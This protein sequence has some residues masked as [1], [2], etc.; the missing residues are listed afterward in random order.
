MSWKKYGG[1]NKMQNMN[2]IT[3]NSLVT[4]KFTVRDIASEFQIQALTVYGDANLKGNAFITGNIRGEGELFLSGS[5]FLGGRKLTLAPAETDPTFLQSNYLNNERKIGLNKLTAQA[6]LDILGESYRSLDVFSDKTN[7]RNILARTGQGLDSGFALM[8]DTT[9]SSIEIYNNG[10]VNTNSNLSNS[11]PADLELNYYPSGT[12]EITGKDYL[13]GNLETKIQTKLLIS[14][15][16][17]PT[18]VFNESLIVYDI[19]GTTFNNGIYNNGSTAGN[20]LSL[21]A[22]DN[23]ANTFLNITTPNKYGLQISGGAYSGDITR[24]MGIIDVSNVFYQTNTNPA[25]IVVSGKDKSKFT[26]TVGFNTYT[27]I[28]DKYSM[29]INGLINISNNDLRVVANPTFEVLNVSFYKNNPNYAIMVG[30]PNSLGSSQTYQVLYSHDGGI[31]WNI[32]SGTNIFDISDTTDINEDYDIVVESIYLQNEFNSIIAT[33]RRSQTGESSIVLKSTNGGISYSQF[34]S[35]VMSLSGAGEAIQYNLYY[36]CV[37]INPPDVND[38]STI[39]V[40]DVNGLS[41]FSFKFSNSDINIVRGKTT[42]NTSGY[43][44]KY[45]DGSNNS[46]YLLTNTS[47]IKFDIATNNII[48][49]K[50]SNSSGTYNKLR[51]YDENVVIAVGENVI[52]YT[53][54]GGTTWNV[55]TISGNFTDV[56]ILDASNAL[57]VGENGKIVFSKDGFSNWAEITDKQVN[58]SGQGYLLTNDQ[59][60]TSVYSPEIDRFI[61]NSITTNYDIT[62]NVT[63]NTNIINLYVPDLFNRRNNSVMDIFGNIDISGDIIINDDGKI[64]TTNHTIDLLTEPSVINFGNSSTSIVMDGLLDGSFNMT[65]LTVVTDSSLNGYFYVNKDAS[66]NSAVIIDGV[67]TMNNIV[68]SND[69]AIFNDDVSMNQAVTITGN[70]I[71]LSDVAIENSNLNMLNNGIIAQF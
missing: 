21:I 51:A 19:S 2:N 29:D 15:R 33:N 28:V 14:N 27:P 64:R 39:F 49:D 55:K 71:M 23:S 8:A 43:N 54:N 36:K 3:V 61:I 56:S 67:T 6:T 59:R 22:F 46:L 26:K 42:T 68:V 1:L 40:G 17:V 69:N 25:Q 32:S 62:N 48:E 38:Y 9:K 16:N 24:S 12:F 37:Y 53:H 65:Q 60:L 35:P 44:F 41:Y 34:S 66:F 7:T 57:V 70:T 10:T 30:T 4:D 58:S 52:T 11:L 13:S 50:S 63:G 18:N 31:T 20:A 47:V 45:I 5:G